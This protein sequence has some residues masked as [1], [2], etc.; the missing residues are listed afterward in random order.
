MTISVYKITH[1]FTQKFYLG[2][3]S[4]TNRRFANHRN[5]LRRGLHH[6]RHL[7]R[8]WNIYGEN[9]FSFTVLDVCKTTEEAIYREQLYLDAEFDSGRMYNSSR[10]NDPKESIKFVQT[11]LAVEKSTKSKI[12]SV[13]FSEQLAKNRLLALSSEAQKKRVAT[14]RKNGTYCAGQRVPVVGLSPGNIETA[15]VSI[16]EASKMTGA[17]TWNIHSCCNGKRSHSK[18]WKFRYATQR[19]AA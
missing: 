8:A 13:R 16:A 7:Q 9:E 4:D 11:K 6:C 18:G 2:Y 14:T 3:S 15:F 17:S 19:S 5:M 1:R 10:S 12:K